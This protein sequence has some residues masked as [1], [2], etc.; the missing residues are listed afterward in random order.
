MTKKKG[1]KI[2]PNIEL[3]SIP[4]PEIREYSTEFFIKPANFVSSVG[5]IPDEEEQDFHKFSWPNKSLPEVAFLGVSNAGKST[6]INCL[7]NTKKLAKTSKK[8]GHTKTL[9]LFEIGNKL[10]LVDVPGYGYKS[11]V[12]WGE[13]VENYLKRGVSD[14]GKLKMVYLLIE[15]KRGFKTYDRIILE[16]LERLQVPYQILITKADKLNATYWEEAFLNPQSSILAKYL[17]EHSH[18]KKHNLL[19]LAPLQA[20]FGLSQLRA[21]ILE[22]T[23]I[24]PSRLQSYLSESIKFTQLPSS[25]SLRTPSKKARREYAQQQQE[26]RQN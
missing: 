2:I 20:K 11:R 22:A 14:K 26:E 9:N 17:V 24:I 16:L 18:F 12:E 3:A 21:H 19:F 7:L 6:L 5:H 13:L 8:P 4:H 1:V 15:S 23:K 10:I 25:S